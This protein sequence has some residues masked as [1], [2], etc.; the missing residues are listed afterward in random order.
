MLSRLQ[1][2][3]RDSVGLITSEQFVDAKCVYLWVLITDEKIQ[4]RKKNKD[5]TFVKGC[6]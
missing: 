4:K 3:E 6:S 2:K 5:K 1:N